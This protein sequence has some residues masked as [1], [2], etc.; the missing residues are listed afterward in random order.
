M[1]KLI[2]INLK[3]KIALLACT[4]LFLM[5]C[6][7][8]VQLVTF[9]NARR[10]SQPDVLLKTMEE[11]FL[12]NFFTDIVPT[13]LLSGIIALV[14]FNYLFSKKRV[15]LY[16]SIPVNRKKL[17]IVNYISGI[18]VYI[19]G[20]ISAYIVCTIIAIPNHYMTGKA[21]LNMIAAIII[22]LVHFLFGYSI[23]IFSI[24]LTGHIV[25]SILGAFTISLFYPVLASILSYFS[26]N[27]FVTYMTCNAV[28]E[29]LTTK[30]YWLSPVASYVTIVQRLINQWD[31]K[32][33]VVI[34]NITNIYGT[35][36]YTK[37]E[38]VYPALIM[39][40]VMAALFTGAAYY[41]Y[42]KRPSEAAGKTIA[43]KKSQPVIRIPIVILGGFIGTW[44][45]MSSVSGFRTN[46]IWLGLIIGVLLSHCIL[47]I[48]FNESFKALFSDKIQLV[49]SLFAA[50]A[51]VGIYYGDLTGF[52]KKI[53]NREK[54]EEA[55]VYFDGIDSN[56]SCMTLHED[57]A[58]P[59]KYL[60]SYDGFINYSFERPFTNDILIDKIY[61]LSTIGVSCV[62][63]MLESRY[64]SDNNEVAVAKAYD[65]NWDVEDYAAAVI[66]DEERVTSNSL[67][68]E[69]AYEQAKKWM[70]ENKVVEQEQLSTERKITINIYYKL[71]SGKKILRM[72][73]IPLSKVVMAMNEVY[74]TEEFNR[75]H[76]DIYDAVS[77]GE[78]KKAEVFDVSDSRV[79]TFTDKDCKEFLDVYL[80][81][82]LTLTID[83]ISE[84]PIGRVTPSYKSSEGFEEMFSGYYIYPSF[85]KTLNYLKSK[86]A[87]TSEFTSEI[88]PE[89][90]Q[91]IMVS[92]YNLYKYEDGENLYLDELV[93]SVNENKDVIDELVP[94]MVNTYNIW[95]NEILYNKTENGIGADITVYFT[96]DK[97]LQRQAT[98]RFKDGK[99]PER[100]KRDI[101]VGIWKKN[102]Y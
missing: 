18:I 63:D 40:F 32:S 3:Q 99:L 92:S 23:V 60:S 21:V 34:N 88:N 13:L 96:S 75:N 31:V 64:E 15:D 38:S 69:E 86:G 53:P 2:K 25:V 11:F 47:E 9:E 68:D 42:M 85:E 48:I 20:L 41:L 101:A 50:A 97:G 61:A 36:S 78:I 49:V 84:F 33:Y 45:M 1:K 65:E 81:D 4:I 67:S 14:F 12:P 51:I 26:N 5:L 58:K 80:E 28:K 73:N 7:P 35:S 24:M 74:S 70:E 79:M 22:N 29:D 95:S 8:L 56:L 37:I 43:F 90:V 57:P 17:F 62:D 54:I 83:D 77:T 59:G 19:S 72:Y 10:F 76:F 39:P 87:D 71:K 93:Y 82:L 91:S 30:Y 46:W 6:R 89:K 55:A 102:N 52:D 98:V 44:F 94:N 100:L 27:M 16:H 66:N